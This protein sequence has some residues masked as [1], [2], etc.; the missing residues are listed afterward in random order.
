MFYFQPR[1]GFRQVRFPESLPR[2]LSFAVPLSP[3]ELRS[4]LL[5]HSRLRFASSGRIRRLLTSSSGKP[6]APAK[7]SG[8]PVPQTEAPSPPLPQASRRQRPGQSC[9]HPRL[10]SAADASS[11]SISGLC[12]SY[13]RAGSGVPVFLTALTSLPINRSGENSPNRRDAMRSV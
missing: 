7:E 2:R 8:A 4:H 13:E 3:G 1:R 10:S 9:R 5:R 12:R 11:D 6:G